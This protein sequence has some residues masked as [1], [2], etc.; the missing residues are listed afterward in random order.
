MS[1]TRDSRQSAA[2]V[3]YVSDQ[4][5]AIFITIT[6]TRRVKVVGICTGKE[7]FI[8]TPKR[9]V[10]VLCHYSLE[11]INRLNLVFSLL[12]DEGGKK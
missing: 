7:H 1:R 3:N 11:S 8:P 9:A 10:A 12:D 4:E 5:D 6:C 2:R